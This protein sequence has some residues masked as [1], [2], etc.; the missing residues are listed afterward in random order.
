MYGLR[1]M[2]GLQ[3]P[4]ILSGSRSSKYFD[5]FKLTVVEYPPSRI[6]LGPPGPPGQG[7]SFPNQ[8]FS[9]PVTAPS[10]RRCLG[11][12]RSASRP[13]RRRK[14]PRPPPRR[15]WAQPRWSAAA[16]YRRVTW[17]VGVGVG[18]V[19]PEVVGKKVE[20]L[21]KSHEIMKQNGKKVD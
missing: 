13:R 17:G 15:L 16:P 9:P 7:R 21:W 2:Y 1:V 20:K 10:G 19:Q 12:R 5:N 18:E 6:A 14:P 11:W 3:S 8:S 4:R